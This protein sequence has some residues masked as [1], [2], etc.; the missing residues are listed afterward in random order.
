MDNSKKVN[1]QFFGFGKMKKITNQ[2]SDEQKK[3]ENKK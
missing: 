2:Q 3:H 1:L